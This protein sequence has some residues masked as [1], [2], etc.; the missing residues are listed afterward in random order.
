[1]Q[2]SRFTNEQMAFAIK[3]YDQ[4]VFIFA[5]LLTALY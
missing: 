5:T 2:T 1:M 3:Q 4:V